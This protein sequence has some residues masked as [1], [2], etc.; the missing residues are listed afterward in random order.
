MIQDQ[1]TIEQT[2]ELPDITTTT[3]VRLLLNQAANVDEAVELL[4]QYDLHASFGFM[5]H[6]AISDAN[7][8]QAVIEYVN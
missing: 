2:S 6:F 7:G 8:E 3:A 4:K 5:I 1:A